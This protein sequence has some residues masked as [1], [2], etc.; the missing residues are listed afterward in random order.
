MKV[1]PTADLRGR[2]RNYTEV[3]RIPSHSKIVKSG[4]LKMTFVHVSS[5]IMKVTTAQVIF[6]ASTQTKNPLQFIYSIVKTEDI[7]A[8]CLGPIQDVFD[9]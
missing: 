5:K 4:L 6:F 9:V 3:I 8:H 1:K 7:S 2:K